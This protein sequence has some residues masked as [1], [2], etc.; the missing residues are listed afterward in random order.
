MGRCKMRS[1]S[2][3]AMKLWSNKVNR[4]EENMNLMYAAPFERN[5]IHYSLNT[6][7]DHANRKSNS[8]FGSNAFS[9]HSEGISSKPLS[10][11][12]PHS[13]E[14][15]P[16]GREPRIQ[17]PRSAM[18]SYN[19]FPSH[20]SSVYTPIQ[21]QPNGTEVDKRL[22]Q[23]LA[24][25]PPR[26]PRDINRERDTYNLARASTK[27]S[28][29]I[30]DEEIINV[31]SHNKHRKHG[32]GERKYFT[33]MQST[34]VPSESV[35]S[36]EAMQSKQLGDAG[37]ILR[38]ANVKRDTSHK[39]EERETK[40]GLKLRRA[41]FNSDYGLASHHSR[42]ESP[43]DYELPIATSKE[44][45]EEMKHLS[46][47]MGRSN[48]R[49]SPLLKADLS[50]M[51]TADALEACLNSSSPTLLELDDVCCAS[52]QNEKSQVKREHVSQNSA[53]LSKSNPSANCRRDSS[54]DDISSEG[55][56]LSEED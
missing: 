45:D 24:F 51:S 2:E 1:M 19:A 31:I 21:H 46:S 36:L 41:V 3:D 17:S 28:P 40:R 22:P 7:G 25:E 27:E 55:L 53:W 52:N 34:D 54:L 32:R 6:D 20:E 35:N 43:S 39:N 48:L 4:A 16:Y 30:P 33:K 10:F 29:G 44:S 11:S 56:F 14:M 26:F 23:S 47:S 38:P 9:D 12:G 13:D 15:V 49:N 5:N 18:S 8:A 50:R 37:S 42:D